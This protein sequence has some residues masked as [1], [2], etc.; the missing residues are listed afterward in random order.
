VSGG[1]KTGRNGEVVVAKLEKEIVPL[2]GVHADE[3]PR[4]EADVETMRSLA[5]LSEGGRGT[6]ALA[7]QIH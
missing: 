3:G 2:A 7:S 5:P 4:R 6:A 1:E